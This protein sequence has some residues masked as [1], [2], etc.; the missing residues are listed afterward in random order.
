[1]QRR[2]EV[3]LSLAGALVLMWLTWAGNIVVHSSPDSTVKSIIGLNVVLMFLDVGN[4][5]CRG[6]CSTADFFIIQ[7]GNA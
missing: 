4:K 1:M 2:A 7:G 5:P 3:S 6:F